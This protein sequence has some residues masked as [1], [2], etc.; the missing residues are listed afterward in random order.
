MRN[1][2]FNISL[3]VITA[4]LLTLLALRVRAGA[5]V[6][7][8]AVLKTTGMTCKSCANRVCAALQG[9]KG[10]A[11]TEVDL[12]GGKV[13]VGY[14]TRAVRPE[15]LT[16]SIKKSGF[17]STIQE[18]VT[19]EQYRQIAGKGV[20]ANGAGRPGGCGGCRAGDKIR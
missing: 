2:I 14:D 15:T 3:I 16:A 10:V 6:D 11:S 17:D 18:V 8:V 4:A 7:S 19:P 9:I 1:N 20:G 13:I 5:T 12:E